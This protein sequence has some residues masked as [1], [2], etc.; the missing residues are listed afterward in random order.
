MIQIEISM[1]LFSMQSHPPES[2]PLGDPLSCILPHLAGVY[3]NS[4]LYR[5]PLRSSP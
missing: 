5:I 4:F 3:S 1:R 2:Y